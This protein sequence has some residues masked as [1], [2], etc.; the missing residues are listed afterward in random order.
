MVATAGL[1]VADEAGVRRTFRLPSPVYAVLTSGEPVVDLR[2]AAP[3]VGALARLARIGCVHRAPA[4]ALLNALTTHDRR[5]WT[6]QPRAMVPRI[7]PWRLAHDEITAEQALAGDL[8]RLEE[9]L[10]AFTRA[11]NTVADVLITL[12]QQ[13]TTPDQV[14]ALLTLWPPLVRRFLPPGGRTTAALRR[15][16]LPLPP[17][18]VHWPA[19]PTRAVVSAWAAA[20]TGQPALADHLIHALDRNDLVT[21]ADLALL[22]DVL[23]PVPGGIRLASGRAVAFLRRAMATP[24]PGGAAAQLARQIIDFLADSGDHAALLAQRELEDDPTSR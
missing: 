22:V 23:G 11:P 24:S 1:H 19:A 20:N 17:D 3:A 6:A 9:T 15:A 7:R 16:L 18:G 4:R 13:A 10:D 8:Q 21:S 12:S 5:T 14:T 2:L